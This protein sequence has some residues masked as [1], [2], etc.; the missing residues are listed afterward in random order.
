MEIL[1]MLEF[2]K[3]WLVSSLLHLIARKNKFSAKGDQ[4]F[5]CPPKMGF[6]WI[7]R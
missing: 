3:I 5:E 2:G 1:G 6:G 7:L 4:R